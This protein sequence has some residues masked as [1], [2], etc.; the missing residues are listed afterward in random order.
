MDPRVLSDLISELHR[1]YTATVLIFSRTNNRAI[2]GGTIEQWT[3]SASVRG[4]R[5]RTK[6]TP[7]TVDSGEQMKEEAEWIVQ[8]DVGTAVAAFDRVCASD[9]RVS[10][11]VSYPIAWRG[12][13]DAATSY[14]ID[15]GV[16]FNG[17][18]GLTRV[19]RALTTTTG[20]N[21]F[22][23]PSIWQ[24]V[25]VDQV[26]SAEHDETGVPSVVLAVNNLV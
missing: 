15:D 18:T 7:Y 3:Y 2:G 19:Y 16:Q 6:R 11:G 17:S 21:P 9:D 25:Q 14:V 23:N 4:S 24:V 8:V 20:Q 22:V 26:Q 12:P 5:Q 1:F 13:W 10:A